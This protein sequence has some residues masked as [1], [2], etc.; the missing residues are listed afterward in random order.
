M[1]TDW[2]I[3]IDAHRTGHVDIPA[4]LRAFGIPDTPQNRR[5]CLERMEATMRHLGV[6]TE[7]AGSLTGSDGA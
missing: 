5:E 1:P 3:L 4:V 2:T 6:P 7:R